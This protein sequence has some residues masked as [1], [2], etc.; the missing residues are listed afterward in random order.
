MEIIEDIAP[1][2]GVDSWEL[3]CCS[4][5]SIKIRIDDC[6]D[7]KFLNDHR[8]SSTFSSSGQIIRRWQAMPEN[9]LV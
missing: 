2:K 9:G 3:L 4:S 5:T 6:I 7:T 1:G 8:R